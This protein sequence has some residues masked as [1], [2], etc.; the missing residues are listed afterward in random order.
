MIRF[1]LYFIVSL[2][3]LGN[4]ILCMY[5]IY[6]CIIKKIWRFFNREVNVFCKDMYFFL[7]VLIEKRCY[8]LFYFYCYLFVLFFGLLEGLLF[9]GVEGGV[10]GIEFFNECLYFVDECVYIFFKVIYCFV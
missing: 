3:D 6:L 1:L 10:R 8:L 4:K 2:L 7:E 9:W 5:I